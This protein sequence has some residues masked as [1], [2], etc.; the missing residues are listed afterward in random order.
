MKT[1]TRMYLALSVALAAVVATGCK[2]TGYGRA[3][4]TVATM[5]QLSAEIETGK[6]QVDAVLASLGRIQ[7]TA[8]TD[9]RPAFQEFSKNVGSLDKTSSRARKR[10]ESLR[11][12]S[13][14]HYDTWEEELQTMSSSDLKEQAETRLAKA[15]DRFD[16]LDESL[17]ALGEAY[18]PFMAEVKDLRTFLEND[19]NPSGIAAASGTIKKL[20][21]SGAALKKKADSVVAE[22][23]T[24]REA[25]NPKQ[26]EL[27]TEE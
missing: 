8:S 10:A 5:E 6:E 20:D 3:G 9:P 2:S 25:V 19:L 24:I 7:E 1:R 22:I 4:A 18:E 26:G 21:K 14:D 27:P 12:Q 15:R 23:T 13:S 11:S 17:R 16:E